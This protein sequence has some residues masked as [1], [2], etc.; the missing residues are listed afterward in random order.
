M[1]RPQ[2][3]LAHF[4]KHLREFKETRFT[5][6]TFDTRQGTIA[7]NNLLDLIMLIAK[8]GQLREMRHTKDL[9]H[10]RE[11][12]KFLSHGHTH[13]SADALVN[14]VEAQRW[15]FIGT[16]KHILQAKQQTRRLT[17]RGDFG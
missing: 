2:R 4:A 15:H 16:R 13:A 8:G 3:P 9:M 17:T 5:I 1:C 6:E 11:I 14:F 7:L 12:P 10:A